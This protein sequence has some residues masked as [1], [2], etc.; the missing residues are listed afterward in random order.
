MITPVQRT[1][2]I[3]QPRWS[4]QHVGLSGRAGV[5]GW[6]GNTFRI[7]NR[8]AHPATDRNAGRE[9]EKEKKAGRGRQR[10]RA[11]MRGCEMKRTRGG[12]TKTE[13]A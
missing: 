4:F 5:H 12:E 9:S 13:G 11:H 6:I 1:D 7:F 2:R 10:K 8:V 3:G